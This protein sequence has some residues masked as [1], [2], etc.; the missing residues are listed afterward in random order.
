[1]LTV[2]DQPTHDPHMHVVFEDETSKVGYLVMELE[3]YM[4]LIKETTKETPSE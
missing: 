4:E 3:A 1:M 2:N